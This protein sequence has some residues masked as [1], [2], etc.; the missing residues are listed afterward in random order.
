MCGH[1][2]INYLKLAEMIQR[3]SLDEW[4]DDDPF[5]PFEGAKE[6]YPSRGAVHSFIPVVIQ[7]KDSRKASAF[8]W[9]LVPG[10]WNKPLDEKRFAS[11]NARSDSLNEKPVFKKAWQNRRRCLIPATSFYEWPDKNRTGPGIKRTEHEISIQDKKLFSMAGIWDSSVVSGFDA[12]LLS[13]A[14]ITTEANESIARIPHTRMPVI[15]SEER[16][17]EWLDDGLS[18]D[19]AFQL[20]RPYPDDKLIIHAAGID[21]QTSMI[22]A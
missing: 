6:Y 17:T 3:F 19:S 20:L 7:E 10:W 13:C 4:S 22:D 2:A 12:P 11:F 9:D 14:I 18:P 1:F 21:N 5:F 15:L 16:E 8:R